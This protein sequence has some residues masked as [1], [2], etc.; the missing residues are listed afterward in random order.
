MAGGFFLAFDHRA[1][2]L[3]DKDTRLSFQ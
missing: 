2:R 1:S 3:G